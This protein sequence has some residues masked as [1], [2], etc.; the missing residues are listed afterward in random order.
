MSRAPR[1]QSALPPDRIV[2]IQKWPFPV[3]FPGMVGC[4]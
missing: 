2:A 1:D 3:W 4:R